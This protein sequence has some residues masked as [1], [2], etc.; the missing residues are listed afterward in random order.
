M[1]ESLDLGRIRPWR[2]SVDRAF[3]ELAFQL[4]REEVPTGARVIRTG[5][6]DGGVEWFAVLPSGQ[7]LG[8]QVKNIDDID[9]LLNGM[10]NSV[11]QI[12][13]E[14]ENLVHL[15]FVISKNL[16]TGTAKNT[17]VSERM[18][19]DNKV[20]K[21]KSEIA[22]A[23]NLEFSLIQESDL[24]ERLSR[25]EHRGRQWFWWNS[26]FL[27]DDWL[28]S[29]YEHRAGAAGPKYRPELNVDLPIALDLGALGL[30]SE[31]QGE[32]KQQYREVRKACRR[33]GHLQVDDNRL[34]QRWAEAQSTANR[35]A[36]HVARDEP[37]NQAIYAFNN[38]RSLV[39][40][41]LPQVQSAMDAARDLRAQDRSNESELATSPSFQ[42]IDYAAH[43]LYE[44]RS[45]LREFDSW[46]D[47]PRVKA[48]ESRLYFLTG[49]A[50]SGK[51]HLFLDATRSALHDGRAA[52]CLFASQI[53]GTLWT[54]ICDQLGLPHIGRDL[55]LEAMAAAASA[56]GEDGRFVLFIDALNES[57]DSRFWETYLPE[58]RA[59]ILRHP[60]LSLA[61]SCRDT[62]LAII[63]PSLERE[64]FVHREHPGFSG[65]EIEATTKYFNHYG[66]EAPRIPLLLPEFSVPLFLRLYCE[67]LTAN[68]TP[69][70]AIGHESRTVIFS[71]Y[72]TA[73]VS[74]SS[75]R[76]FGE[77]ETG[78]EIE[79]CEEFS[80]AA[81]DALLDEMVTTGREWIRS[82]RAREIVEAALGLRAAFASRLIGTFESEGLLSRDLMFGNGP[83]N[84][85]II[86]VTF[87]AFSD[88]L[89]LQRRLKASANPLQDET[90]REWFLTTA[91]W[92]ILE[93]A[94]V[95]IPELFG[96]E[97]PDY[98]DLSEVSHSTGAEEDSDPTERRTR[99]F[100]AYRSFAESLPYRTSASFTDRTIKHFNIA[101][102]SHISSHEAYRILFTC[103]PQPNSRLNGFGLHNHL[104]G[105]NLSTRD[106]TFGFATYDE[107]FD[108][109]SP[110]TRLARWASL[111]PYP[112]YD[113]EVI[114]LAAIPLVWMLSTPNRPVRDWITKCLV[115]LLHERVT[116]LFKLFVRFAQVDDPFVTQRMIVIVYGCLLRGGSLR[117][118]Q[119]RLLVE[120]VAGWA[121]SKSTRH[122]AITLDAA[123]SI[124]AWAATNDVVDPAT[125]EM[126]ERPLGI[127]RPE[128]SPSGEEIEKRFLRTD[129]QSI[130]DSHSL[131]YFSLF[132]LGDFGRYVVEN[133]VGHFSRYL[134]AEVVPSKNDL[135]YMEKEKRI[136]KFLSSLSSEQ[137][138]TLNDKLTQLSQS[139]SNTSLDVRLSPDEL[140]LT[141]QQY[142]LLN[143]A[144]YSR[145]SRH[146]LRYSTEQAKSWIFMRVLSL[147]WQPSLF[148]MQDYVIDRRTYSRV[149]RR[150]ERWGKKY[151]WIA[152]FELLARIGDNYHR[153]SDYD[154]IESGS[155]T[156]E[157][158]WL[159]DIDPTVPPIPYDKLFVDVDARNLSWGESPIRPL[160]FSP[161][162]D[163]RRYRGDSS[164]LIA[165]KTSLPCLPESAV[166]TDP[167]GTK[168]IVL[169]ASEDQHELPNDLDRRQLQ[170]WTWVWTALVAD[171]EARS[172][173]I[174]IKNAWKDNFG[175][176]ETEGHRNCCFASEIGW[177]PR[178]CI[179]ASNSNRLV[180][181]VKSQVKIWD[182]CEGYAWSNEFDQSVSEPIRAT[183]PSE[184][185]Q[186]TTPM[187]LSPAGPSWLDA[188]GN[189]IAT[190]QGLQPER[191]H[192]LFARLDWIQSILRLKSMS[193]VL[194]LR[195]DRHVVDPNRSDVHPRQH[196]WS[197]A[198]VDSEGDIRQIGKPTILDEMW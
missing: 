193:L 64:H 180:E 74:V 136:A 126:A 22:G 109:S 115:Q 5:N 133:Y 177:N 100:R 181:R 97:L 4:L 182:T 36:D 88:F 114:E 108:D 125:L 102:D 25:P 170:Q 17:R 78:F 142:Q 6:P 163:F 191:S 196:I 91:S 145:T 162:L 104:A 50:G 62:Y 11:R 31:F 192:V 60:G 87:Q 29:Q 106:S 95:M 47:S 80:R 33:I 70:S 130:A 190:Y 156:F 173:A 187:I 179:F 51:T 144:L 81:I 110:L 35:M 24:L 14:R 84:E 8:W 15:T 79:S 122:D 155:D 153:L 82:S 175:G 37:A 96:V 198:I 18:K 67:G 186:R 23:S 72:L 164:R 69:S 174:K 68:G 38:L 65:H 101:L 73:K 45:K 85:Q 143:A 135:E 176:P 98:L 172:F 44:L 140:Q 49:V 120:K 158:S 166:L 34:L 86:R 147:G 119:S 168:W 124:L 75:R 112:N 52:V 27:G 32:L 161:A 154:E 26:P 152:L 116:V 57:P 167:S 183:F 42:E 107:L 184:Y 151:Q 103:A 138:A 13:S 185:L 20:T 30:S 39:Q 71:R 137:E 118:E 43:V 90:L 12:A 189:V 1:V 10:T 66:L 93:A 195:V 59:A 19:F 165:D 2:G 61:V 132:S 171:N 83:E 150:S 41:C 188:D 40:S 105:L 99:A 159:R 148:G 139:Q 55:L 121:F 76:A 63:D 160:R 48:A 131:L 169:G 46:L 123:A 21:W 146:D 197:A 127:E 94:A 129:G 178:G 53:S 54:S 92:G 113:D 128:N 3:E 16:N 89:L 9:N 149:G 7:E 28:V 194:F 134:Q 77:P 58:I 117:R 141:T 56:Q 111:G 157:F